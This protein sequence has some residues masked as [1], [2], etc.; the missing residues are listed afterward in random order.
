MGLTFEDTEFSGVGRGEMFLPYLSLCFTQYGLGVTSFNAF[1]TEV[2]PTGQEMTGEV[3]SVARGWW[4][5]TP[6]KSLLLS[7]DVKITSTG[8]P[9][10]CSP[11]P[12]VLARAWLFQ[13]SHIGAI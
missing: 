9:T 1:R 11:Q 12:S 4:L 7:R 2:E 6:K 8:H 3:P 10:P 13:D 5:F